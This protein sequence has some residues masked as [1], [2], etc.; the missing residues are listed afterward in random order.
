MEEQ[1]KE[2]EFASPLLST[3]RP[4]RRV[5]DDASPQLRTMSRVTQKHSNGWK[6]ETTPKE[7][8]FR[9]SDEGESQSCL[10]TTRRQ[11]GHSTADKGKEL[12]SMRLSSS[13]SK[14]QT[15]TSPF[16]YDAEER[17]PFTLATNFKQRL[18][19]KKVPGLA[20]SA[21][22]PP[23]T[24]LEEEFEKLMK[25]QNTVASDERKE[26]KM[27][28]VSHKSVD[29]T[30][31][32]RNEQMYSTPV[33]KILPSPGGKPKLTPVFHW[34]PLSGS[35]HQQGSL[36][37]AQAVASG[38]NWHQQTPEPT[39]RTKV[40][41]PFS[42][43]LESRLPRS[44]KLQLIESESPKSEVSRA[45]DKLMKIS[46]YG[47]TC[48]KTQKLRHDLI[49]TFPHF[50]IMP[51]SFQAEDTK[52]NLDSMHAFEKSAQKLKIEN[53][54]EIEETI[55][56][57]VS[58]KNAAE[59][60]LNSSTKTQIA[61]EE[62]KNIAEVE[63][64]TSDKMGNTRLGEVQQISRPQDYLLDS[65]TE[66]TVSSLPQHPQVEARLERI[67]LLRERAEKAF[68]ANKSF[69]MAT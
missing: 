7:K 63:R 57:L 26:E 56:K 25:D 53:I 49:E 16:T 47:Y 30:Q 60:F 5:A 11:P 42:K 64:K 32:L 18:A 62:S 6:M 1:Q 15:T 36:R 43:A 28:A 8:S 52:G 4:R 40:G 29:K 35:L 58:L 22:C 54:D 10:F 31:L 33:G 39:G 61:E 13:R 3:L 37:G 66:R 46:S 17:V 65:I 21:E 27:E 59:E 51:Y 9:G 67:K 44:S 50:G 48:P 41:T 14:D 20:Q 68:Q 45:E 69:E 23:S 24:T 38:Y 19:S 34:S 2:S 55:Q 12:F